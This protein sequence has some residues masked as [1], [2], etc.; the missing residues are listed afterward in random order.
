MWRPQLEC[1][2]HPTKHPSV[3]LKTILNRNPQ[4]AVPPQ[5][6]LKMRDRHRQ[7]IYHRPVIAPSRAK[8]SFFWLFSAVQIFIHNSCVNVPLFCV[9]V[10]PQAEHVRDVL[11]STFTGGAAGNNA[12]TSKQQVTY[13]TSPPPMHTNT[14][15]KLQSEPNVCIQTNSTT[16]RLRQPVGQTLSYFPPHHLML[17]LHCITCL[18]S[19]RQL[20]TKHPSVQRH[21]NTMFA[22]CRGLAFD[23]PTPRSSVRPAPADLPAG[24]T[25]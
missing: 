5:S 19:I 7:S 2:H 1:E 20:K 14:T 21:S 9:A 22:G 4:K 18:T 23:S 10:S 3:S 11:S 6:A 17:F 8:V 16:A 12:V 25:R 13:R 15:L 24:G